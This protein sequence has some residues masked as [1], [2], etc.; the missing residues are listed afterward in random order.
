[1]RI[2]LS[3]GPVVAGVVGFLKPKY[4][5]WGATVNLSARLMQRAEKNTIL[6][7]EK[8]ENYCKVRTYFFF[9]SV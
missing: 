5:V 9:E 6:V 1:V 2:G 8:V 4:D 3:S 7:S